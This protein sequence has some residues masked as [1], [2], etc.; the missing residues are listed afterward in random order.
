[1]KR[2]RD[3]K[4]ELVADLE[5]L[6]ALTLIFLIDSHLDSELSASKSSFAF[7]TT[8]WVL[9]T[10]LQFAIGGGIADPPYFTSQRPG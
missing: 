2:Q 1:M 3:L 6:I 5:K 9:T 4:S 10:G 8:L 7:G